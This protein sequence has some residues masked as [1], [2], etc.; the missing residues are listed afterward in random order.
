MPPQ[1]QRIKSIHI[2]RFRKFRDNILFATQHNVLVGAN[3]SGKTSVLHAIRLFFLSLGGEFSGAAGSIK[4]H[5]RYIYADDF[6]PVADSEEL[7]TDCQKGNTRST[8]IIIE[9]EFSSGLKVEAIFTHRFG[10]V[11]VD[12]NVVTNP[13][14]F[15]WSTSK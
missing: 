7:W 8:G 3:N 6:L 12:A 14:N 13:K 5:R 4:F 15:F 1:P 10:Q 9:I 2:K 11:H